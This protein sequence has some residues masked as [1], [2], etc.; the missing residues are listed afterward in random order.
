MKLLSRLWTGTGVA[1]TIA[2][3]LLSLPG[4]QIV[5]AEDAPAS[6]E[7]VVSDLVGTTCETAAKPPVTPPVS[8]VPP[9]PSSGSSQV[10]VLNVAGYNYDLAPSM[11]PIER[12]APPADSR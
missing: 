2:T 7:A 9:A 3:L 4:P 10:I 5:R 8:V 1:A 11:M 6:A 12:P